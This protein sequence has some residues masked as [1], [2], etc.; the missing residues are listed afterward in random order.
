VLA[1]VTGG[2][3]GNM[4]GIPTAKGQNGQACKTLSFDEGI[5]SCVK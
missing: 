5:S 3:G 4:S 1:R 2:S